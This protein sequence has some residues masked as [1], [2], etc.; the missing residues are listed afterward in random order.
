MLLKTNKHLPFT[1]LLLVGMLLGYTSCRRN[2]ETSN[3]GRHTPTTSSQV[4]PTPKKPDRAGKIPIEE[5]L[6]DALI[7]RVKVPELQEVLRELKENP[8]TIDEAVPRGGYQIQWT[9]LQLAAAYD[10]LEVLQALL[11]AGADPNAKESRWDQTALH[12]A[13]RC[14][15]LQVIKALIDAGAD[16]NQPN[17][18]GNTPFQLAARYNELEVVEALLQGKVN[19]N[20]KNSKTGLTALHE[21]AATAHLEVIKA[22]IAAEADINQTDNDGNTPL[23][24]AVS[25]PMIPPGSQ[26]ELEAEIEEVVKLLTEQPKINLNLKNNRGETA[27]SIATSEFFPYKKSIPDILKQ[28]AAKQKALEGQ[29]GSDAS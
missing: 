14:G 10:E 4:S 21:A 27:L 25:I 19:L 28:C 8:A 6:P 29:G 15:Y 24:I 17:K 11:Q 7:D 23:H 22:L 1:F 5:A 2:L 13:V 12:E 20:A 26:E 3:Q 9:V 16:I 18:Y